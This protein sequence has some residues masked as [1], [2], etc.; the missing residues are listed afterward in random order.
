MDI[1]PLVQ[2]RG[3]NAQRRKWVLQY[4]MVTCV[5]NLRLMSSRYNRTLAI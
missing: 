5:V 1:V 4:G 3:G 2:G